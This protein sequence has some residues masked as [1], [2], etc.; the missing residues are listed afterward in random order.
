MNGSIRWVLKGGYNDVAVVR[1][2]Q[3]GG[4]GRE[5]RLRVSRAD[6][7]QSNDVG[8]SRGNRACGSARDYCF[9]SLWI[10]VPGPETAE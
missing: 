3:G 4:E 9:I 10:S 1:M 7:T 6:I 8:L 5:G 2:V